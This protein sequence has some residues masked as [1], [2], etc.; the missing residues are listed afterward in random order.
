MTL[1]M[2]PF[3]TKMIWSVEDNFVVYVVILVNLIS[4]LF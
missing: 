4:I 2:N 3:V 1:N